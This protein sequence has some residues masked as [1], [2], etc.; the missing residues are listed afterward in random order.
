MNLFK[1]KDE[2]DLSK[3]LIATYDVQSTTNLKELAWDI[4][5]GQSVGNPNVRSKWEDDALFE[6]HS[7]LILNSE[8]TLSN[9]SVGNIKIA[10][11]VANLDPETDGINHL[12]CQLMGGHTD[13][14]IV[15]RCR[16]IDLKLPDTI[17][18]T[19]SGP[20]YGISGLRQLT[21]NYNKPLLGGIIKPK[22]VQNTTVLAGMV[23]ELIDGGVDFIKE[24]EIMSSVP[25]LTLER[26]VEVV[27]NLLSKANYK[28]VYCHTI[29]CDPHDLL[30]RVKTVVDL[31]GNGV[32]IN[33]LGGLG[34]YHSVR[35]TNL[36]VFMHLQSSGQKVLT[37]TLNPYSISWPVV[38][39]L[40][41]LMGVDSIQTGMIGGYSNDDPAEILKCLDILRA[42]NTIPALS[43]GFHPGM[44]DWVT[45]QVGNDYLANSGS[46]IHGHP[47]G[48]LAGTRAMRQAVDHTHGTEYLDAI[49]TWGLVE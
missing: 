21:N 44:V 32:H 46:A 17:K 27:A 41:T 23:S 6:T 40:A 5:V 3:Y 39:Q 18:K 9:S 10:F 30:N 45:R 2:I 4:A 48:T 37:N 35:K 42:G 11:P 28:L 16:L 26:R 36:P 13:I 24:D 20:K 15:K 19:F 47:K 1:S 34:T 29:N 7:C 38:C 25:H 8:N 12:I 22:I 33:I 43:C 14:N 31:G 49:S